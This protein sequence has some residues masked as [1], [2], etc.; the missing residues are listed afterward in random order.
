MT[1]ILTVLEVPIPL[2]DVCANE[3]DRE[4]IIYPCGEAEHG[5][6]LNP[7]RKWSLLDVEKL[8][9]CVSHY[10]QLEPEK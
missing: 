5:Y 4:D 9:K 2:S 6:H 7:E 10:S 8:A 3:L 1:S